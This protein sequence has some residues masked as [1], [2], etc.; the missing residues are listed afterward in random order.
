MN[1]RGSNQRRKK[2][3]LK[4]EKRREILGHDLPTITGSGR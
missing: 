1:R 4:K 2:G 3:R